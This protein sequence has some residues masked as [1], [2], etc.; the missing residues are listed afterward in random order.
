MVH[1]TVHFGSLRE[2]VLIAIH[3]TTGPSSSTVHVLALCQPNA[4]AIQGLLEKCH[5]LHG[6]ISLETMRFRR[7]RSGSAIG[8][9]VDHD[10][11]TGENTPTDAEKNVA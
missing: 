1:R 9:L 3:T 5:M 8:V 4:A 7:D 6:D 10:N 11:R 2:L